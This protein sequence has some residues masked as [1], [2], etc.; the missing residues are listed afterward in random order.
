SF[1]SWPNKI[2]IT[3]DPVWRMEICFRNYQDSFSL[4][5]DVWGWL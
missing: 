3:F 4:D 2:G 1:S 5:I